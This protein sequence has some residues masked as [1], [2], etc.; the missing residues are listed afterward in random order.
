MNGSA[1]SS[2]VASTLSGSA[3]AKLRKKKARLG[4]R[5]RRRGRR[6]QQSPPNKPNGRSRAYQ[7][8]KLKKASS[9]DSVI[10]RA[11]KQ[12]K[13]I[14][15][16]SSTSTGVKANA[17][18]S[19]GGQKRGSRGGAAAD[20]RHAKRR[21]A[22]Q[23]RRQIAASKENPAAKAAALKV[24]TSLA[25]ARTADELLEIYAEHGSSF[26]TVNI[27]TF[28]SRLGKLRPLERAVLHPSRHRLTQALRVQT[29]ASLN[30]S[31]KVGKNLYSL[32]AQSWSTQGL[33][34]VAHAHG[35]LAYRGDEWS[36][37]M[38]VLAQAMQPVLHKFEPQALGNTVWAYA[39]AGHASPDLLEA[40]AKAALPRLHK[41]EPMALS[42]LAWAYAKAEH[43]SPELF[44]AVA[45]AALPH[46]RTA[47]LRGARPHP[48]RARFKP[49]E[50]SN[51]LWAYATA[52]HAAPHL[53]KAVAQA[54]PPRLRNFK[55]QELSN[56]VW[57]YATAGHA[58][59]D[60]FEAVAQAALPQ[61]RNFK[62]QELSNTAWAYATAGHASP[63]LF[64]A[65]AQAALPQLH[66]FNSQALSNTAWAYA[67]AGH[68]SPDLFK[69]VAQAALPLLNTFTSQAIAN[70]AWA[71]AVADAPSS[72]M[73]FSEADFVT[74]CN[75][76]GEGTVKQ[77]FDSNLRKLSNTA[78]CQLHKWELWVEKRGEEWPRL[79]PPLAARC[80]V[81]FRAAGNRV[82][83]ATGAS[84]GRALPKAH[85]QARTRTQ[86][87]PAAQ[88]FQPMR[89]Q[90]P[91]HTPVAHAG[92]N[93]CKFAIGDWLRSE[94]LKGANVNQAV[95]DAGVEWSSEL[96]ELTEGD[97]LELCTTAKL[98]LLIKRRLINAVARL[99][100]SAR[101]PAGGGAMQS[102]GGGFGAG[103]SLMQ[104][105][106]KLRASAP[107]FG[108]FDADV[109][110]F[111]PSFGGGASP[112]G[113]KEGSGGGVEEEMEEG[114]NEDDECYNEKG[115]HTEDDND[116]DGD[117]DLQA[118][119]MGLTSANIDDAGGM[120]DFVEQDDDVFGLPAFFG[121]EADENDDAERDGLGGLGGI[122]SY[123][124]LG[125]DLLSGLVELEGG[126]GEGGAERSAS[127]GDARE[128]GTR[129]E[130]AQ[131]EA[132]RWWGTEFEKLGE[133]N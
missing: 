106:G 47:K 73:L 21:D 30:E 65:V 8:A 70:M 3:K 72:G 40:V 5:Q 51:M 29:I 69:A 53:F 56:T 91:M 105:A 118:L 82:P 15:T 45:Q 115:D 100:L 90:Q 17:G 98:P 93:V 39:K 80:R 50:M 121:G 101:S 104:P 23:A 67:T 112:S 36:E 126:V 83:A 48:G 120:D 28:W 41:F 31:K 71:F 103:E 11:A 89:M 43:A 132:D 12:T 2:S 96:L 111:T 63:D 22:A 122:E 58:S 130:A 62:P 124:G 78:L 97:L 76:A 57:A 49:E 25:S 92:A 113:G 32:G 102:A 107:A 68:A 114:G 46:L 116:D 85:K 128:V 131:I 81:A 125:F 127:D 18:G 35:I 1:A 52:G 61:L 119:L 94:N 79:S 14:Q 123:G 133:K 4:P 84:S 38:D 16:K 86:L 88:P 37:L 42:N 64:E 109:P 10:R 7:A 77:R 129:A 55:P 59:P 34:N 19:G 9:S 6:E 75:T 60:L 27:S 95:R 110:E 13:A 26:A 99:H 117:C 66:N 44:T 108:L 54:A 24:N 74:I 33:A 20:K 87:A